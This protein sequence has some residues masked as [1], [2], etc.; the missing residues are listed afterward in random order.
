MCTEHSGEE[1]IYIGG[2][3]VP[4]E[5]KI[6][7]CIYSTSRARVCMVAEEVKSRRVLN[8][9]IRGRCCAS[10]H[11]HAT[12]AHPSGTTTVR[13]PTAVA[14]AALRVATGGAARRRNIFM[15]VVRFCLLEIKSVPRL[16]HI[17]YTCI[18]IYYIIRSLLLLLLLFV[19]I[20][21]FP[22]FFFFFGDSRQI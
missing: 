6:Y 13:A 15:E 16:Y 12:S 10:Q 14:A 18:Y 4:R 17:R 11:K 8:V 7:Y 21:I 5:H 9:C 2:R 19:I 20:T 3:I 22:R 1:H